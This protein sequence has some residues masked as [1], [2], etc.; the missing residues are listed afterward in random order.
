MAICA[1]CVHV[2]ACKDFTSSLFEAFG[3][4]KSDVELINNVLSQDDADEEACEHF[5]ARARVAALPY[6][7]KPGDKLWYILDGLGEIDLMDYKTTGGDCAVGDEP[8]IVFDVSTRGF[9]IN[10][11]GKRD[12]EKLS[13]EDCFLVSWD[14]IGKMY[15]LSREEAERALK[16]RGEDE[17]KGAGVSDR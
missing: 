3:L 5:L 11:L 17:S 16:E 8:D 12:A 10:G 2:E 14:E 9:W 7:V 4:D 13:F 1:E 15:F 6:P